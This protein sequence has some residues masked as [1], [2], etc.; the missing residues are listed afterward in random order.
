[1]AMTVGRILRFTL[2]TKGF[3]EFAEALRKELNPGDQKALDKI[4]E[5][6]GLR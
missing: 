1:M 5:E 4:L 6:H 3:K 2:R